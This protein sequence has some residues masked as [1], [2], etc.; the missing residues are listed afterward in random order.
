MTFNGTIWKCTD[1]EF[2]FSHTWSMALNYKH[3]G[4]IFIYSLTF[5]HFKWKLQQM[6]F[7]LW[8]PNGLMESKTFSILEEILLNCSNV[9]PNTLIFVFLNS[10]KSDTFFWG[11]RHLHEGRSVFVPYITGHMV[12]LGTAAHSILNTAS[13]VSTRR[14]VWEY[15]FNILL[16]LLV[17]FYSSSAL[18]LNQSSVTWKCFWNLSY[19]GH[20]RSTK[21]I[22]MQKK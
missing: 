15:L 13:Y 3:V 9:H 7:T 8:F 12:C 14:W 22:E 6:V 10:Q 1:F 4:F 18:A 11:T 5:H 17:D 21:N 19:I 20:G 2:S 16:L